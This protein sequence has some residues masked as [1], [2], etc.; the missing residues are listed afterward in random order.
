METVW[1]LL[2]VQNTEADHT[3]HI[4]SVWFHL[5]SSS[6]LLGSI[7]SACTDPEAQ[8]LLNWARGCQLPKYQQPAHRFQQLDHR[9][10]RHFASFIGNSGGWG[11]LLPG[12]IPLDPLVY[13]FWKLE[14]VLRRS[15]TSC[16]PGT[17]GHNRDGCGGEIVF[18]VLFWGFLHNFQCFSV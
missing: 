11:H 9:V 2:S 5:H 13:S 1:K 7:Q 4:T 18:F 14:W 16:D 10:P 6:W 3:D 8:F 12:P 15:T 17:V